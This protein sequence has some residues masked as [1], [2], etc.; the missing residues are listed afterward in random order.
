MYYED[1]VKLHFPARFKAEVSTSRPRLN[2]TLND[3]SHKNSSV[4]ISIGHVCEF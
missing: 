2:Q 3:E 4:T 1:N